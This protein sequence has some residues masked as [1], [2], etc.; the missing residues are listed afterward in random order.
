MI[1]GQ[2]LI[3]CTVC[4]CIFSTEGL[5]NFELLNRPGKLD[6]FNYSHIFSQLLVS[7]EVVF[8]YLYIG[9]ALTLSCQRWKKKS[10]L[11]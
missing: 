6:Y 9:K 2:F 1:S 10:T 11:I 8:C 4:S 3:V 7:F 5:Q